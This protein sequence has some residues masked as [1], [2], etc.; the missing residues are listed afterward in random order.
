FT[1]AGAAHPDSRLEGSMCRCD[2]RVMMIL[3]EAMGLGPMSQMPSITLNH[4]LLTALA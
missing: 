2:S 4:G 1:D 3:L